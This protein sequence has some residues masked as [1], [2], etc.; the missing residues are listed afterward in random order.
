[1]TQARVRPPAGAA[2]ARR[3]AASGAA[4]DCDRAQRAA[5]TFA[6]SAMRRPRRGARGVALLTALLIVALAAVLVAG[7]LD[8]RGIASARTQ[9]AHRGAQAD[10]L[11]VALEDYAIAQLRRDRL[12]DGGRDHPADG[13]AQPLPPTAVPGGLVSGALVERNGCI[14]LN[15]LV[16]NGAPDPVWR[17]RFVQLLLVLE[18]DP[19]IADVAIDWI[20]P[21]S[22]PEPR[23][24]EDAVY[25]TLDPPY[26]AANGPFVDL[27]ELRL[28]RGVDDEVYTALAPHVCA[29]PARTPLN[30]NTATVAVVRAL[31]A[32]RPLDERTA[33][34]LSREGRASYGSVDDVL[35]AAASARLPPFALDL[36]DV[37]VRSD[38]FEARAQVQLDDIVI[39]YGALIARPLDRDGRHRVVRRWRG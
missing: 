12:V 26:R 15:N 23:G 38:W 28:L 27:S 2:G 37:G 17:R 4:R 32:E 25:A 6:P 22:D 33:R 8:V 39:D 7:L 31:G 30:F 36:S 20:D 34:E 19:G 35:A 18:L 3:P 10:L 13:W 21:G 24:A 29:L 1:M 16:R 11:A 5:W 9:A 14:N